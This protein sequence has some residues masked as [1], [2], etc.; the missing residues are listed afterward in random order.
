MTTMPPSPP[1]PRRE[2][3]TGVQGKGAALAEPHEVNASTGQAEG[4]RLVFDEHFVRPPVKTDDVVPRRGG[5]EDELAV[6]HGG[7]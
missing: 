4:R 2:L 3:H 7:R 6:R 1:P 5:G